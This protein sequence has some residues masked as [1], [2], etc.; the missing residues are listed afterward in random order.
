M[1]A[2][3]SA[4][5]RA[6]QG[7]YV[8]SLEGEPG[9]GKSTLALAISELAAAR[10]FVPVFI[11]ADEELRGP[12][13]LARSLFADEMLREAARGSAAEAAIERVQSLLR[14]GD[15]AEGFDLTREERLIRVFDQAAIALRG[16]AA[17][18]PLALFVDDVQ[19]ADQ[20]SIRLLRYLVRTSAAAPIFL[21]LA[22]RPEET[23]LV[24]E[25]VNLLADLER[26][27]V[28]DRLR[29]ARF[30]QAE[31]GALLHQLLGPNVDLAAVA[32]VHAQAE[33]VPFIVEELIRTYREAGLVQQIGERWA[34]AKNADRLVPSAVRTLIQRRAASLDDETRRLLS[35]AAILGRTFRVGDV[36]AVRIRLGEAC[37][38]EGATGML[39]TARA[40][41]LIV[42]AGAGSGG[43]YAFSH[44]QVR[45]Y[46]LGLLAG[47]ER[48]KIHGAI[49]DMLTADGDPPAETLP[50]LVRHAVGAADAERT[51]RF[52][53]QAARAALDANAAEEAIRLVEQALAIVSRP[54]DRVDLLRVRDDALEALGRPGERLDGIAEFAALA[55]AT[56]DEDL[57]LEVLLRRAAALRL[58]GQE[59]AAAQVARRVRERA[60]NVGAPARELEA[61]LELGQDLLRATLGE[62][63]APSAAESDFVG[64]EEA[65]RR[66]A[67]LAEQLGQTRSLAAATRELGVIKLAIARTWFVERVNA[68]DHIPMLQAV[69]AGASLDDMKHG[70]P[71]APILEESGQLMERSLDLFESI[72]DRRGAMSA[73]IALA[74]LEWG[75]QL[76][77]GPNP[78]ERFEGIRRLA[79]TRVAMTRESER[80]MAEA[81]MLYG[82]HVF[83]RSKVIPDLA[84]LRGREAYEQ[85]RI[86]GESNV[87]F[88]AAVGTA[89]AY[90][91][92][93][94]VDESE[95][96]LGRAEAAA[97]RAPT[98]HR[99]MRAT[100]CRALIAAARGDGAAMVENF[101]R[102]IQMATAQR[103][104]AAQCEIV[105]LQALECA[106]L[107]AARGDE[108]LLSLAEKAAREARRLGG[109][110]PGHALWPAEASAAAARVA[111]AR[112][113]TDEALRHARE[114][115]AERDAANREDPHLEILLPA[116]R[117][118]LLAGNDEEK[119]LV[120]TDLQLTQ[121][122]IAQRSLDEDLRVRWF[123]GPLGSELAELAGPLEPARVAVAVGGESQLSE[124]D[125]QLLRMLIE[126][127]TNREIGEALGTDELSVSRALASLYA[128]IGTESRAQATAFA[129]R[130]SSV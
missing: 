78:A 102:A 31:T 1:Q 109:E 72:G 81:Q 44:E 94:E 127:R 9:I 106:R 4:L 43:D 46:A 104:P 129:L 123:R 100:T 42:E 13:L 45:E 8:V 29:L 48:R 97:A 51:A 67:E 110:L 88:L 82:V 85:A 119:Q 12:F 7:L 116:A 39:G 128:R 3:E 96:W 35:V 125:V 50:H 53:L 17:K 36:C 98:P 69:A 30:R 75:A 113:D 114:A 34:L 61:C 57:Q 86:V 73:I 65:F 18:Q 26:M 38:V 89:L 14:G 6:S 63:Y 19:W 24:T 37:D 108:H 62:G 11:A 117:A 68:G 2:I 84:V 118:V 126:G 21:M 15:D 115:I 52:S 77:F 112:G 40:S 122:Q 101:E 25:L 120:L 16:L 87:E 107:G 47:P 41:G 99:A 23:V 105:A 32:T 58:D 33:G 92:L 20:D 71:I 55:E 83:A 79:V 49:A 60:S 80:E 103:R 91:D 111:L 64:A 124:S 10:E 121:A 76:H 74:Y 56:A 59:D 54:Q 130:A 5:D 93:G 90:L 70:L 95:T 66:A 22:T 27:G 28:L